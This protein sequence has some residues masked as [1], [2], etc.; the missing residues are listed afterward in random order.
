[1]STEQI[2]TD[3]KK[4]RGFASLTPERRR[5]IASSGGKRAQELGTSHRFTSDEARV[6]GKKGGMMARKKASDDKNTEQ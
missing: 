2:T 3:K 1:M 6:A 4:L 5:E